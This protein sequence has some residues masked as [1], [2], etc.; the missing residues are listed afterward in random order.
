LGALLAFEMRDFPPESWQAGE[1]I[2]IWFFKA[3]S[4]LAIGPEIHGWMQF[5]IYAQT[6]LF[7][8]GDMFRF[9]Y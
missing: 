7:A 1:L 3:R 2:L 5:Q 9:D 4:L 8:R 6:I